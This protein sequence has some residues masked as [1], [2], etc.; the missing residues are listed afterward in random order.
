MPDEPPPVPPSRADRELAAH[1]ENTP[2]AVIE[3]DADSRVV[4][5]TGQAEAVFGWPAAEVLGKRPFDWRLVH[6]DDAAAVERLMREMVSLRDPRT[7]LVNRNYTR[8]GAV[9]WCEW[10]NSIL[11]DDAGRLVSILSLVLDITDRKA[12]AEAAAASD[13]R[14]RSALA[15][16][17]MLGWEWDIR[18]GRVDYSGCPAAFYGLPPGDDYGAVEAAWRAV[19]PGDVPAVEAAARR[20]FEA[21]DEWVYE[22]RG[23]VPA[24]DGGDRWF[25]VRGRVVRGADG[26]PGRV[27]A[28][29][30]DVTARK[31]AE[32][33]REALGRRLADAQK[34]EGL[35]VMAGGVAHDFNNILTVILGGAALARQATDPASPA[36]RFLDEIERSAHR[37]AGLCR[38]ML[39]YA[40]RG[41]APAGPADLS[42]VV[43]EEA[44]LLTGPGGRPARV[45]LEPAD[46][47][48]AVRADP[49]QVRQV[50]RNLAANAAEASPDG[51]VVTVRTAAAEV[52]PGDPTDGYR[53]APEP[54]RYVALEVADAGHGMAPDVQARM[55]DPFFTTRF[56]GRGLGLAAVLGIVRTH[57]GAIRVDTAPGRGTTVR[58][59]W[60]VAPTPAA[61]TPAGPAG[62][63]A[64]VVDDEVFIREV[65]ASVVG[66]L[67]YEP[68]L[69]GNGADGLE[70]FG[71]HRAD[72]RVAVLDVV[73]PGLGGD[74][75]LA[76]VR[77]SAPDLPVVVISGY[78]DRGPAAG[79]DD[80]TVYLRKPFRPDDL[81]DAVRRAVGVGER[82]PTGS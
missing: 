57:R 6:D 28:V 17:G 52:G 30:A 32:A 80:R 12:A 51:G 50:L 35:G 10:H 72:L 11:L 19:H 61:A 42:A 4:R 41:P 33:E 46:G 68:V 43:R 22:F 55:F 58:V 53:P 1:L 25:S 36:A 64:L 3:W 48:P 18:T 16:A 15:G 7:V 29:T 81:T 14:L 49:A 66:E 24:A 54:G 37:A 73:M 38:H 62:G 70:L 5:W 56:P 44:P 71:R 9:I 21:G 78:A 34:W 67:G 27:V 39:A 77:R 63:L 45:A 75:L 69:A 76:A 26:R 31:R 59:L 79:P 23:A 82:G 47:L 8:A 74:E 60:P 40:G 13:A 65:A 20:A 2:L